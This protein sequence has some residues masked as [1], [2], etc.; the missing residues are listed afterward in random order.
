MAGS[1]SRLRPHIKTCKSSA[2][3]NLM[4]Q[5]GIQ[6]FKCATI[7]EAEML[8][9]EQAKDVLLAYQ[10]AGPKLERFVTLLKKYPATAYSCLVDNMDAAKQIAEKISQSGLRVSVYID[11][12]VGMNRTGITPG[13]GAIDLMQYLSAQPSIK[14]AGLHIYDG[15]ISHPDLEERERRVNEWYAV[16]EK[17][18]NEIK[19]QGLE[20]A[21]IITGGSP[22]FPI[23]AKRKD[24]QCS[25]GTF[26]YWDKSYLDNCPEQHFLPA[27]VLFTHVVSLPAKDL[28][29]I[30]L[31]HKS[32]ASENEIT[33]R[34]SFLDNEQLEPVS[35]SEEHLVLRTTK[36]NGYT[37]GE[38]L[39]G[40]PYHVCPTV[41]LYERLIAIEEGNVSGE[42]MNRGRDR[43]IS[44]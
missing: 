6:Q 27:V 12:N 22:T 32:I 20:V 29:T 38:V 23:H 3:V 18:I 35:H 40:L 37:I 1:P 31:G 5:A 28:V 43:K 36:A 34:I 24:L 7:A 14:I 21:T 26:V 16:I 4:Q 10:P 17:F 25:P 41:A 13:R 19:Q 30:D 9:M 11:I 33:R 44:V 2:A 39:Y 42:W 8:G 15:H